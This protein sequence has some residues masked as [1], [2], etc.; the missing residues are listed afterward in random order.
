MDWG[1]FWSVIGAIAGIGGVVTA[2]IVGAIT[3]K[4]QFPKRK[5][6]WWV[7]STRLVPA[8]NALPIEALDIKINGVEVADPYLNTLTIVSNS[9]ADIPTSSFDNGSSIKIKMTEGGAL[10]LESD[11]A[12]DG[13]KVTGGHGEGFEW[14]EFGIAPQLIRRRA[15][16]RFVFVSSGPP[17]IDIEFP[18]IDIQT[19]R[20]TD[21]QAIA[22][23][24]EVRRERLK[25]NLAL[26][27]IWLAVTSIGG[28]AVFLYGMVQG[29][30]RQLGQ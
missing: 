17:T 26:G 29:L 5:L 19:S 1:L 22:R 16:G 13:I 9:R 4:R 21:A 10:Q 28:G 24:P 8:R 11:N 12:P 25:Y 27:F 23:R 18:L 14:A 20:L 6:E 7:E 3:L 30:Q 15:E 2:I